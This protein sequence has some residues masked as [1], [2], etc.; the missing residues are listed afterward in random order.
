MN[1]IRLANVIA[2]KIIDTSPFTYVSFSVFLIK[3]VTLEQY[4]YTRNNHKV[5]FLN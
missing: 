3:H 4:S 5:S 1:S 2:V